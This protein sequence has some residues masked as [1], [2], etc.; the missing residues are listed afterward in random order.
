MLDQIGSQNLSVIEQVNENGR[1][2]KSETEISVPPIHPELVNVPSFDESK[3]KVETNEENSDLQKL[4]NHIKNIREEKS[5][6]K[7]TSEEK[8]DPMILCPGHPSCESDEMK[9]RYPG[10]LPFPKTLPP[11]YLNVPGWQDCLGSK[12]HSS[13]SAVCLPS[14][15]PEKCLQ[16]SWDKLSRIWDLTKCGDESEE[17]RKK[18]GNW[19]TSIFGS[20]EKKGPKG[21]PS[22]RI[23]QKY[24]EIDGWRHCLRTYTD[25]QDTKIVDEYCLPM[26]KPSHCLDN[27]WR[28]MKRL[29]KGNKCFERNYIGKKHAFK[30]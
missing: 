25:V 26:K 13:H 17:K 15:K 1:D 22:G 21:L 30:K 19:P 28:E 10:N 3:T 18:F 16:S 27:S 11:E 9:S 29:W 5:D 4:V 20:E 24:L 12:Q 23:R 2:E 6:N 14:E 8:F 7:E